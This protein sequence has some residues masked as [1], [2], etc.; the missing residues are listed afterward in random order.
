MLKI[1][2]LT[3]RFGDKKA[4]DA[5]NITVEKPTMIGI[6]Q[7]IARAVQLLQPVSV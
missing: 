5:A 3:K 4:V 1:D 2:A 6:D 7:T